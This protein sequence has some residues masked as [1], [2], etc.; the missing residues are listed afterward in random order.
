[1]G[2]KKKRSLTSEAAEAF[3]SRHR[4]EYVDAL[5]DGRKQVAHRIP[6]KKAQQA[7]QA[8]R[9]QHDD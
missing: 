7:R 6:N 4:A 3:R 2:K 8:C 5:R 9:G 1:M